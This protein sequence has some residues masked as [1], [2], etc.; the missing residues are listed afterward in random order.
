MDICP[1]C[2]N[3]VKKLSSHLK[4]CSSYKEWY[5]VNIT[6]DMLLLEYV[7]GGKSANEISKQLGLPSS[8]TINRALT[9]F[10]IAKR[11]ISESRKMDRCRDQSEATNLSRYGVRHN[12]C[13]DHPSRIAWQLRLFSEEGITN[14][15]QRESVKQKIANAIR[16]STG[17]VNGSRI[18]SIHRLVY[19]TLLSYG[20]SVIN[21]YNIPNTKYW[22]D[23]LVVG[24]NKIIEVNG[25]FYHANPIKYVSTDIL[26][27]RRDDAHLASD[28]WNKDKV[29]NGTA[30][31]LGFDVLVVWECDIRTQFEST[32]D[33]ILNFIGEVN[34]DKQVEVG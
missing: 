30:K 12:M 17:G 32:I 33:T 18:S 27:F 2:N 7:N 8:T 15:F 9:K 10:G 28:L 26:H 5:S 3:E 13:N 29:K 25:D 11:G 31:Q 22:Y 4:Y 1:H 19:N 20:I 21:E 14:V 23:I 16:N 6:K 24:T 34:E